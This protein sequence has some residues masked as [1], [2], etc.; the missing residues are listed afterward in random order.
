M[1][2]ISKSEI[3]LRLSAARNLKFLR[4]AVDWKYLVWGATHDCLCQPKTLIVYIIAVVN[5]LTIL[6]DP[7]P[8]Y[9]RVSFIIPI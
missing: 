8:T 1:V 9:S 6:V 3:R 4:V 5:D 7:V 2:I